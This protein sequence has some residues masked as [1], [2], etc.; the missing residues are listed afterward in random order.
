MNPAMQVQ[1]PRPCL[2]VP[3]FS[4]VGLDE[5]VRWT[6][7]PDSEPELIWSKRWFKLRSQN[8]LSFFRPVTGASHRSNWRSTRNPTSVKSV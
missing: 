7:P 3:L 2:A 5:L 1:I 6:W 4:L 8:D